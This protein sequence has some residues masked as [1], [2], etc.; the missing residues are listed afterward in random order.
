MG[1]FVD[2]KMFLRSLSRK[3]AVFLDETLFS[4]SASKKMGVFLDETLFSRSVAKKRGV[5]LAGKVA[6]KKETPSK[7]YAHNIYTIIRRISA[8]SSASARL[9]K[10]VEAAGTPGPTEGSDRHAPDR[11]CQRQ[12][13]GVKIV[14]K[15]KPGGEPGVFFACY[16]RNKFIC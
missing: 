10:K 1:D 14:A 6:D 2:G 12:L 7:G 8:A 3:K 13:T 9:S 15:K 4:R 5:F 16:K 11:G